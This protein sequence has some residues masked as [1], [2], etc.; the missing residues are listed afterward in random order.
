MQ[1]RDVGV[2]PVRGWVRAESRGRRGTVLR[3]ARRARAVRLVTSAGSAVSR[4]SDATIASDGRGDEGRL[5][6]G[7]SGG[8]QGVADPAVAVGVGAGEIDPGDAVHLEVDVAR[9]GHEVAAPP[10]IPTA[11]TVPSRESTSTSPPTSASPTS[12]APTPSLSQ[13]HI[14]LTPWRAAPR[15][16]ARPA[17][18]RSPSSSTLER[19]RDRDV[20]RR[21]RRVPALAAITDVGQLAVPSEDLRHVGRLEQERLDRPQA[22]R[23]HRPAVH[24]R[25]AARGAR[26]CD[27]RRGPRHPPARRAVATP[28]RSAR[29]RGWR[30]PRPPGKRRPGARSRCRRAPARTTARG[31]PR[32]PPP[33]RAGS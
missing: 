21:L 30:S 4:A 22:L 7:H 25:G 29:R 2:A 14:G 17:R 1:E 6:R 33:R 26:S 5:V 11:V 16:R 12:A 32:T 3:G 27:G 24:R 15:S 19:R 23:E 8:Q 28:R 20:G 31:S 18:A 13:P 9:G 10:A